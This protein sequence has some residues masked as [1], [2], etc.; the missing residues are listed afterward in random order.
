MSLEPPPLLLLL[1]TVAAATTATAIIDAGCCCWLLVLL[2]VSLARDAARRPSCLCGVV[3]IAYR[4]V[5]RSEV[6]VWVRFLKPVFRSP[7]RRHR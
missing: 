5:E 1:V 6:A 3:P 4:T 7:M 2:L